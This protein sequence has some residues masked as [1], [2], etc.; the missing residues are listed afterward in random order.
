MT[1]FGNSVHLQLR[2]RHRAPSLAISL[3]GL[4]IVIFASLACSNIHATVQAVRKHAGR[5]AALSSDD[6]FSQLVFFNDAAITSRLGCPA[7]K[8]QTSLEDNYACF[9]RFLPTGPAL[10]DSRTATRFNPEADCWQIRRPLP[11]DHGRP[12]CIRMG[13]APEWLHQ[14]LPEPWPSVPGTTLMTGT[15]CRHLPEQETQY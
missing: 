7:P 15:H 5:H 1:A 6:I 10:D 3:V 11:A 8:Q 9:F 4:I 2:R 13:R 12:W 14:V